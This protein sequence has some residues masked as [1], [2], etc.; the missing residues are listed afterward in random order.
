VFRLGG[1]GN[2]SGEASTSNR[3][4]RFNGSASRTTEDWKINLTANRNENRNS[5]DLG[6]DDVFKSRSSSW[7]TSALV[8]RSAGPRVSFGVRASLSGS[9]FANENVKLTVSPGVEFDRFPYKESTRRSLTFTYALNVIHYDY[10]DLT[11]Y[12]RLTESVLGHSLGLS[13]GLRQPWG[14]VG[15]SV[16]FQQQFAH[17][18]RTN[19]SLYGSA[20]VRLFRGFSF[21]MFG[22]YARI[23]DQ[24]SLRKG[25]ASTEDV[26]LRLRQLQSGFSYY[27]G[28]GVSYSFGSIFNTIVNPRYGGSGGGGMIFI[29]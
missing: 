22:D 12:D 9:T 1:N 23:R 10:A 24:I 26:L 29:F 18:E 15:T 19:L 21:N 2:L 14:S 3:S 7:D 27:V 4:F 6:E 28:F 13:L 20:D 8:V 16:T 5:Y 17:V 25:T 11:I